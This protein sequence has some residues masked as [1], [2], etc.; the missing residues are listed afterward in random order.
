MERDTVSEE[1]DPGQTTTFKVTKDGASLTS[2]RMS[3]FLAAFALAAMAALAPLVY[4]LIKTVE[5]NADTLRAISAE[6]RSAIG[7]LEAAQRHLAC[8]V[9]IDDAD[10]QRAAERCRM[11]SGAK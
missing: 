1:Q 3:E 4:S 9:T 8:V 7:A 6:Q 5:S 2:K 11:I 10:R